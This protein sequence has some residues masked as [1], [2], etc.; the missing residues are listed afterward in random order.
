[1]SNFERLT[2]KSLLR[3]M[4][5]DPCV[6]CDA[7]GHD[8]YDGACPKLNVPAAIDSPLAKIYGTDKANAARQ[9][10][11]KYRKSK[12]PRYREPVEES[13]LDAN[14]EA[15]AKVKLEDLAQDMAEGAAKDTARSAIEHTDKGKGTATDEEALLNEILQ[16]VDRSVNGLKTVHDIT[17]TEPVETRASAF[18][19]APGKAAEVSG[20]AFQPK[21]V[22]SKA[23]EAQFPLR[24]AFAQTSSEVFTNHFQVRFKPNTR[25]FVYEI[26]KIP[27]GK[28]QRKSKYI[29]KTAEEAWGILRDN[30]QYYATDRVKTIVAWK[31]LHESIEYQP[32]IPGDDETQTGAVWQPEA[33]A[34]GSERVQLFFKLHRE[35]DLDGLH[36]YMDASHNGSDPNFNFNPII[37]AL[38][39]AVAN[40]LTSKV[41]QQSS[42]KFFVKGGFQALSGNGSLKSLCAI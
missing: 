37:S 21:L 25:F 40:S 2:E 22:V 8:A 10:I 15:L 19:D 16:S 9:T 28:S 11:L 26:L 30:K 7:S 18:V 29:F 1:M 20:N 17:Q 31:N 36:R 41:F 34:D 32:I 39:L 23:K 33:I 14:T 6:V 35:L 27:G 13:T 42:N 38:N 3:H 24:K 12:K 4:N 5:D